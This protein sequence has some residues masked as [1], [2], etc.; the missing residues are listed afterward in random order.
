MTIV[1]VMTIVKLKIILRSL[2]V[3]VRP[4]D[5]MAPLTLVYKI[6]LYPAV[7]MPSKLFQRVLPTLS[8]DGLVLPWVQWCQW[9]KS[10]TLRELCDRSVMPCEHT[11]NTV[12][13]NST[14]SRIGSGP[15]NRA[16]GR[17]LGLTRDEKSC[18]TL[19]HCV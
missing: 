17:G 9:T 3:I 18:K 5:G 14:G 13:G 8:L 16:V 1:S 2:W 10:R 4:M 7:E 15:T 19:S 6:T 11:I 12:F